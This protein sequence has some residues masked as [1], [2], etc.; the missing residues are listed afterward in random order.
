MQ[1]LKK[2]TI[3]ILIFSFILG[4]APNIFSVPGTSVSA[5]SK[6]TVK[7]KYKGKNKT[8][9]GTS[10]KVLYNSKTV[11]LKKT[12]VIVMSG[13]HMAPYYETFVKGSL[14]AKRTYTSKTKT[15]VLTANGHTVK[16]KAESKTAYVDGKKKKLA[17]APKMITYHSS[18]L[19]RF[20]VPLKETASFLG[21]TYTWNKKSS[22]IQLKHPT[23][24]SNSNNNASSA[25]NTEDTS[26]K[27]NTTTAQ[28]TAD[29]E[30]LDSN[31]SSIETPDTKEEELTSFDYTMSFIRPNDVA[32]GTI[33][34]Q[35]DYKN[36]RLKIIMDGDQEEFYKA[37]KPSLASGVTFSCKYS[38][39]S[40]K[41]T[42]YFKTKKINGFQVKEDSHSIYIRH[43][44]PAKIF[45]NVIVL[46]A[47][48]GGSD[49]GA[50]GNGYK[51]KNMTLSIVKAAKTYFDQN[52]DYK[53][54][55]TR[56]TDTYPSLSDR[57]QLANEVNADL[58]ISVHINSAG[59][60]A[61]GT[62][63]LYNPD[64]NKKSLAGLSCYK[65]A[66]YTHK[67]VKAATG[68]TNR[69]L[70]KRCSRLGNGLAVLSHNNGPATL[71]EIGF[72]SNPSEAKK[73]NRNLDSYG[74]A[75]YDSV[76]YSVSQCPTGR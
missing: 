64:R 13:Y 43:G 59:K 34:C 27:E 66:F 32:L 1:H 46:D 73:M 72:I 16:F 38:A 53:V 51:E 26:G 7:Y 58:F 50:T 71:T 11:N 35:D 48:H 5:A 61:T 40:H 42:L 47:G 69:G 74:K 31:I 8:F 25:A 12:P 65:L 33:T 52:E 57:Y 70:K 36:K 3:F 23:E 10:R 44:A 67:Y 17:I 45:K 21:L 62:E 22:T 24:P 37:N 60:T 41:T 55:Y 14:K 63:T 76:L 56:L 28:N 19:T 18:K 54:Y 75:I 39:S 29:T 15:L 49:T 68:F 4:S 6:I 9:K 2:L 20:M 30:E